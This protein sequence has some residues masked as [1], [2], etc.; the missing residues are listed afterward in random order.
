MGNVA[1]IHNA[2][3][4]PITRRNSR[5]P[6]NGKIDD[7]ETPLF[8]NMGGEAIANALREHP[9]YEFVYLSDRNLKDEGVKYIADALRQGNANN[10]KLVDLSN[11]GL[12]DTS[13]RHLARAIEVN[14]NLQIQELYLEK[15][16][17]YD[18]GAT[19]L[20]DSL[21]SNSKITKV[22][23]AGNNLSDS[24]FQLVKTVSLPRIG[25]LIS[26]SIQEG[27]VRFERMNYQDNL[28]EFMNPDEPANCLN[29]DEVRQILNT[30]DLFV[31]YKYGQTK[32]RF[33]W[34]DDDLKQL[35]WNTK[36]TNS[37]WVKGFI[38]IKDITSIQ[39]SA[40]HCSS[41]DE[42]FRL[43]MERNPDICVSIVTPQRT[44]DLE[45]RTGQ[46]RN[47]FV[48][49][50]VIRRLEIQTEQTS[51]FQDRLIRAQG[52]PTKASTSAG[53]TQGKSSH[54]REEYT[55]LDD[56]DKE[57]KA[58]AKKGSKFHQKRF[59]EAQAKSEP[60][61]KKHKPNPGGEAGVSVADRKSLSKKIRGIL[62][63]E[64]W[65]QFKA[66]SST[67]N[68]GESNAQIYFEGLVRLLGREK[69]TE[70]LPELAAK[71]PNAAR[72]KS[73]YDLRSELNSVDLMSTLESISEI[74]MD[75]D[76]DEESS[77]EV[78]EAPKTGGLMEFLLDKLGGDEHKLQ[79]FKRASVKFGAEDVTPAQ[80][81]EFFVKLFGDSVEEVFPMVID[82]VKNES[83]R[84][85]L[86]KHFSRHLLAQ[87]AVQRQ[88]QKSRE[89]SPKRRA[90]TSIDDAKARKASKSTT[91]LAKEKKEATPRF[92]RLRSR[93]HDTNSSA[94]KYDEM[95]KS[96][97]GFIDFCSLL[98][99]MPEPYSAEQQRDLFNLL[100]SD[101]D[102]Y[103]TWE[104]FT[105]YFVDQSEPKQRKP[106]QKPR[107]N[108]TE[109]FFQR[110]VD[111]VI[112]KADEQEVQ[113]KQEQTEKF[114][115]EVRR[116]V[117]SSGKVKGKYGDI[118]IMLCTL[119][120]I[121]PFF[122]PPDKFA[123]DYDAKLSKIK[124]TMHKAHAVIHPDKYGSDKEVQILAGL[125]FSNV[126]DSFSR[127]SDFYHEEHS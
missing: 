68:K 121:F 17:I 61:L 89:E 42:R 109:S 41:N 29:P 60:E 62:G 50:L 77:S 112:G 26:S 27:I 103:V 6:R 97:I 4:Q 12:T 28:E 118:R 71:I 95:S 23:F 75:D 76:S 31:K 21:D 96:N 30:G 1:G 39:M 83:Q 18:A 72:S 35:R 56:R 19:A 52:T 25:P 36:R 110:R 33:V 40:K 64:R 90:R 107:V 127:F 55:M 57:Q 34:C 59:K 122:D 88:R 37:E 46:I 115:K 49:S 58:A 106:V 82:K 85:K 125:V 124:K 14:P 24:V 20:L 54:V 92:K 126:N 43:L 44:L 47:R 48:L 94:K 113:W 7:D 65:D 101:K 5:I 53:F 16:K 81:W 69:A 102:G 3:E 10:V 80:Y 117:R 67:Y 98:Q 105:D 74:H 13:A 108:R 15:N 11:N 70:L 120:Q 86:Q 99:S 78:R 104:E 100:D 38:W 63:K 91:G 45:A 116:W 8:A 114:E 79:K 111:A 73:L 51:A 66:L 87:R 32:S 84:E 123:V 22:S 9:E 2:P 119:H 93:T